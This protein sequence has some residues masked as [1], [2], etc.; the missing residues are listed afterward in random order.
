[1]IFE[2]N[3]N[4]EKLIKR[5]IM[6]KFREWVHDAA[7]G[8]NVKDGSNIYVARG[9]ASWRYLLQKP[10]NMDFCDLYGRIYFDGSLYINADVISNLPK[11]IGVR[12]SLQINPMD[13]IVELDGYTFDIFMRDPFNHNCNITIP[14]NVSLKNCTFKRS[15][16]RTDMAMLCVGLS[17][18]NTG[19]ICDLKDC[20]A[21]GF[22]HIHMRTESAGSIEK[23]CEMLKSSNLCGLKFGHDAKVIDI[24]FEDDWD[25]R[26]YTAIRKRSPQ[27]YMP[28]ALRAAK[29]NPSRICG[30]TIYIDPERVPMIRDL[31]W[32]IFEDI[33]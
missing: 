19:L 17:L 5:T 27:H 4:S 10:F 1:M 25:I 21:Q 33:A 23:L 20:S 9:G 3:D 22:T 29:S 13:S 30:G 28:S 32:Y 8:A 11:Y 12:E 24:T 15:K 6:S 7:P 26:N 16:D 18:A 14:R 2:V 31:N